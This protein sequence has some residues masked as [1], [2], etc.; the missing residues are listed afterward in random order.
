MLTLANSI[1]AAAA[2]A[3]AA[4]RSVGSANLDRRIGKFLTFRLGDD[5]F[6]VD[7][8]KV[9]HVVNWLPVSR[10]PRLPANVCGLLNLRGS[11]IPVVALRETLGISNTAQHPRCVI[12]MEIDSK[13]IGLG[14]DQVAEVVEVTNASAAAV[15][16]FGVTISV[17]FLLGIDCYGD[18]VRLLLDV[19]R[20]LAAIEP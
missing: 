9:S 16:P 1:T 12:V 13:R 8:L 3:G 15:P 7:V 14:V 17:E 10:V 4:P 6:G 5:E 2:E 18:R 11:V 19:D 20:L